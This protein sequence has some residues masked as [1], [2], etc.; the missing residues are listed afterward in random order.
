MSKHGDLASRIFRTVVLSGAMLGTP[1]IAAAEDP[2]PKNPPGQAAKPAPP[3][4]ADT[5]DSVNKELETNHTKLDGAVGTY[6]ASLKAKKNQDTAL[7]KV[8]ELRTARTALDERIAKTTRPPFKNEKAG[9]VVEAAET[10]F[11]EADT[12]LMAALDATAAAKEDADVKKAVTNLVAA[13]KARATAWTKVKA[14]RT[15]ANRRPRP[16]VEERPVGRGFILS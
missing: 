1:I 11:A 12:N 3:A 4:K 10:K 8:T 6:I 2:A 13:K 7:A 14:E 5:W 15:K 16:P 9:P